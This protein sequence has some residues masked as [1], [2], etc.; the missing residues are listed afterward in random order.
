MLPVQVLIDTGCTKKMV[1]ANYLPSNCL[2]HLNK[3][4]ILH[5]HGDEVCYPT[6]EVRLKFGQWSQTAK[7]V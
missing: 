6:A 4:R 7:V 1:S 2:D 3:E 5:V